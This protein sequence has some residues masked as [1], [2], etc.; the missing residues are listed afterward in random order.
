NYPNAFHPHAGR[1]NAGDA[2]AVNQTN[3]LG[4][5]RRRNTGDVRFQCKPI[6][7]EGAKTMIR[8]CHFRPPWFFRFMMAL[9]AFIGM[10]M[11]IA[12]QQKPA[13]DAITGRILGDDGN[14]LVNAM[15]Q[16]NKDESSGP[17]RISRLTTTDDEGYFRL[18]NLP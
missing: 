15:V 5:E 7:R 17:N 4:D 8:T 3:R 18:A 9:P 2:L 16:A 14:P 12:T 10:T 13:A 11:A 1:R 6:K